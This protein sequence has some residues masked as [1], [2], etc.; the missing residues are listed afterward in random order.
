DID[1]DGALLHAGEH[2]ARD[3]FWCSGTWYEHG[4][5]DEIGGEDLL[6]QRVDRRIARVDAAAEQVV[7]LA[8][9]RD[10]TVDDRHFRAK[11]RRHPRG[12]QADDT[13]P[14]DRDLGRQYARHASEQDTAA[15]IGLL[16]RG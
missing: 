4:A 15:A 2:F 5:D 14:D 7:E 6:L 12:M 16:Q 11:A 8:Q 9:A 3:E 13:A 1:D 10:R